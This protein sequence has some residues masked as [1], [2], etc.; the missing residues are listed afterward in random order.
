MKL[1]SHFHL[2]PALRMRDAKLVAF[3]VVE[4]PIIRCSENNNDSEKTP[5]LSKGKGKC[6]WGN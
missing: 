4:L 1:A 6:V 3:S 5:D 2:E